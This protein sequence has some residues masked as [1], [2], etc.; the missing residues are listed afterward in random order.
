MKTHRAILVSLAVSAG[1]SAVGASACGSSDTSPGSDIPD[2]SH[3]DAI[4]I[5]DSRPDPA[6]S[7][8]H[9]DPSRLP[10]DGTTTKI[11]V[12]LKRSDGTPAGL[13]SVALSSSGKGGVFNP[14]HGI[15]DDQGTFIA[16]M[17]STSAELKSVAATFTGGAVSTG[18]DFQSCRGTMYLS[19]TKMVAGTRPVAIATGDFNGDNKL[20]IV[21]VNQGDNNV[22][23]L[24]GNGDGTFTAAAKSSNVGNYPS[25]VAVGDFNGDK[26]SDLA[27]SNNQDNGLSILLSN[28][29]GTFAA[30][31]D[32][33]VGR[34]P[35]SVVTADFNGDQKLD[36]AV[37]NADGNVYILLGSPDGTFAPASPATVAI[38]GLARSIATAD[39]DGDHK[40]DLAVP[41]GGDSNHPTSFS[42]LSG[43]GKGGFA[44]TNYPSSGAQAIEAIATG[45]FSGDGKPDLALG[46]ANAKNISI[47]LNSGTGS[48]PP[49][50]MYATGYSLGYGPAHIKVG[51]LNGDGKLDLITV[52]DN[53]GVN[54][55]DILLG[56][57]AST[58]TFSSLPTITEQGER[59]FATDVAL[60]DFNGDDKLDLAVA[61]YIDNGFVSIFTRSGCTVP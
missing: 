58:G 59:S 9:A 24:L 28:G 46:D 57:G 49:P 25:A 39:F 23:I 16:T 20:D 33:P 5:V 30:A 53:N 10:A 35:Q 36:L 56:T 32:Y 60:G 45:D 22:T 40:I 6:T 38:G 18:V 34:L 12:T 52:G 26:K 50:S 14:D 11:T 15:T 44:V 43:D 51:D 29:D 8:I 54:A 42:I 37:P 47:Q 1:L 17:A 19:P 3:G 2:A 55:I 41:L 4:R 48:F 13:T 7:T 21:V 61:H 27:V 31:H